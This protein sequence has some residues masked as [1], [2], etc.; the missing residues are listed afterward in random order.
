MRGASNTIDGSCSDAAKSRRSSALV[1]PV[2]VRRRDIDTLV[3]ARR[4]ACETTNR[5]VR[6][7]DHFVPAA[8]NI[9]EVNPGVDRQRDRRRHI[10]DTTSPRL[11]GAKKR[12]CES[13]GWNQ[14]SW[15]FPI[16][17]ADVPR[18]LR[19]SAREPP[20]NPCQL[21]ANP[22]RGP[23]AR[24]RRR[25]D[26]VAILVHMNGISVVPMKSKISTF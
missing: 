16:T 5:R 12:L 7:D 13:G 18:R 25:A 22:P 20:A 19:A 14:R 15:T 11:R 4:S 1:P 8:R 6:R 21:I 2:S 3:T 26:K 9:A 10:R 17:A 23:T 24:A